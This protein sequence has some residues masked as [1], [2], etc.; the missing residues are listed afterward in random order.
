MK[1]FST[2]W[3]VIWNWEKSI[4]KSRKKWR[5]H[6]LASSLLPE[7]SATRGQKLT[8]KTYGNTLAPP[9]YGELWKLHSD[10]IW[11]WPMRAIFVW[12]WPI[13]WET[14]YNSKP[15]DQT[16]MKFYY[17]F[18]SYNSNR[19]VDVWPLLLILGAPSVGMSARSN[20]CI[21]TYHA[22]V[23]VVVVVGVACGGVK[24]LITVTQSWRRYRALYTLQ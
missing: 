22:V 7:H 14:V 10:G 3:A 24:M 4:K 2:I 21:S 18:S 11:P 12:P 19:S 6:F 23:V 20:T 5:H 1:S 16:M 17:V 13:F 9:L 8:F 15:T